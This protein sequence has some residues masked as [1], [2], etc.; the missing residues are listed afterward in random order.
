MNLTPGELYFIGET[1]LLIM[2]ETPYVKIGLVKEVGDRTSQARASEHQTGNPR[3]LHVAK[4]V[5]THAISEVENIIH[6]LYAPQRISG[7]WFHF[8]TTELKGAISTAQTLSKEISTNIASFQQAAKWK[9]ELSTEKILKPTPAIL[10]T[11]DE[12][13]RAQVRITRCSEIIKQVKDLFREAIATGEEVSHMA[14][15]QEKALQVKFD[16]SQLQAEYPKLYEEFC[17]TSESLFARFGV[18]KPKDPLPPLERIDK[19]FFNFALELEEVIEKAKRNKVK[20]EELFQ[21]YLRLLG[22]KARAELD[23]D[24]SAAIIQ[25]VCK[26][27]GGIEGVCKWQRIM[28]FGETFDE[29]GF[30]AAHPKIAKKFM[31]TVQPSPAFILAQKH[32]FAFEEDD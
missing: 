22:F 30:I 1:D 24:I 14:R 27:A 25:A 8:T 19:Q 20:K 28:K 9:D 15:W 2:K 12:Y 4:V 18:I 32:A 10:K 3:R 26:R 17:E 13:Q 31:V 16:Q 23:Q 11:Y 6:K 21:Q 29:E 7:E 5:K